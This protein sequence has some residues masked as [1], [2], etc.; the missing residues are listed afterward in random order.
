MAFCL[1]VC[2]LNHSTHGTAVITVLSLHSTLYSSLSCC[3]HHCTHNCS[4]YHHCVL[5]TVYSSLLIQCLSFPSRPS[6]QDC[7]LG[8]YETKQQL[9]HFPSCVV[10]RFHGFEVYL[11][12]TVLMT[13]PMLYSVLYP[14]LHSSLHPYCTQYLLITVTRH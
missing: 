12:S 13:V 1:C 3:T 11:L 5:V 8:E 10:L 9:G 6:S 4:S 14:A 2:V 7:E